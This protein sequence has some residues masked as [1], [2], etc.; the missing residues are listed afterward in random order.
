MRESSQASIRVWLGVFQSIFAIKTK[1]YSH[2]TGFTNT[3]TGSSRIT[4]SSSS[5]VDSSSTISSASN[6]STT[7]HYTVSA[8]FYTWPSRRKAESMRPRKNRSEIHGHGRAHSAPTII[9]GDTLRENQLYKIQQVWNSFKFKW[10][11]GHTSELVLHCGHHI[12]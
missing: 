9:N 8:S 11:H 12:K 6:S 2:Y 7:A 10:K 3:S 5:T 1:I 4:S